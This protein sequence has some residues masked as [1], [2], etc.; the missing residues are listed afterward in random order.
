MNKS[1]SEIAVKAILSDDA[2]KEIKLA[3]NEIIDEELSKSDNMD[4]G[5]ISECTDFLIELEENENP[6]FAMLIPFVSGEKVLNGLNKK[7]FKSLNKSLRG[8][9]IVAAVLLFLISSN[10]VFAEISGINVFENISESIKSTLTELGIIDSSD[11]ELVNETEKTEREINETVTEPTVEEVTETEVTVL[12]EPLKPSGVIKTLQKKDTK[13]NE[14]PMLHS[15]MLSFSND[16][17]THY[18][19]G[20]ELKLEGLIVTAFYS[21]ISQKNISISDCTVSG[22]KIRSERR[23]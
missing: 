21:D 23:P 16:F 11:Q 18:Y 5:L 22:Y 10:A 15:I 9:M 14:A 1:I 4:C 2:L 20:E 6:S 7:G 3:V 19:Y 12:N 8:M 13:L 17:K